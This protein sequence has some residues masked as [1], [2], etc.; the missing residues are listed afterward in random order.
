MDQFVGPENQFVDD[1]DRQQQENINAFDL[2]I[3]ISEWGTRPSRP[4]TAFIR[5]NTLRNLFTRDFTYTTPSLAPEI[6]LEPFI[7]P[8][9]RELI[10]PENLSTFIGSLIS[11]TSISP[12]RLHQVAVCAQMYLDRR[13][14]ILPNGMFDFIPYDKLDNRLA[15]TTLRYES[16]CNIILDV[17]SFM[18][19]HSDAGID[20][21]NQCVQNALRDFLEDLEVTS[22]SVRRHDLDIGG[23]ESYLPSQSTLLAWVSNVSWANLLTNYDVGLPFEDILDLVVNLSTFF[24][25]SKLQLSSSTE[26]VNPT[27]TL[28]IGDE[29]TFDQEANRYYSTPSIDNFTRLTWSMFI[30]SL[31]ALGDYGVYEILAPMGDGSDDDDGSSYTES[32]N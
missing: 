32:D 17:Y 27:H 5:L 18:R 13:A 4:Y 12:T 16:L 22:I 24:H 21:V 25:G 11:G 7:A 26:T 30:D 19:Y 6:R 29:F 8:Q 2:V 1:P 23:G 3:P 28:P 20:Y 31:V 15:Q 10:M 9:Y 14:E